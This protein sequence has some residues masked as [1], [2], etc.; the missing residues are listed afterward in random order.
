[1]APSSGYLYVDC[2]SEPQGMKGGERKVTISEKWV[3]ITEPHEQTLYK[4]DDYAQVLKKYEKLQRIDFFRNFKKGR[5]F[6][7]W[8]LVSESHFLNNKKAQIASKLKKVYQD[9][10]EDLTSLL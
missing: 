6:R 4:I 9:V 7:K 1:M 2:Q 10:Y 8:K 3:L 5:I